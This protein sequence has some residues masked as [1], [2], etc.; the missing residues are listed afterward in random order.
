MGPLAAQT[1]DAMLRGPVQGTAFA[2]IA[3]KFSDES[4]AEGGG[5]SIGEQRAQSLMTVS[6]NKIDAPKQGGLMARPEQG[7]TSMDET[8]GA[9]SRIAAMMQKFADAQEMAR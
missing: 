6:R 8:D 3:P 4:A 5:G 9:M 1:V 2:D 7:A